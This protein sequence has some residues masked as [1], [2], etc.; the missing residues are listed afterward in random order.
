MP[1][2]L[3]LEYE[4]LIKNKKKILLEID[5]AGM[6]LYQASLYLRNSIY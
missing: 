2:R 3:Q 1:V 4:S 6:L 5:A